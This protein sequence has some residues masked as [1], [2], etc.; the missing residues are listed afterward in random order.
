MS[1]SRDRAQSL[2]YLDEEILDLLD[3]EPLPTSPT[4]RSFK[5]KKSLSRGSESFFRDTEMQE[6]GT[7]F[8]P[9]HDGSTKFQNGNFEVLVWFIVDY[10]KVK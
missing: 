9:Q 4:N 7:S 1:N 3:P 8:L 10:L 5:S 6:A 2:D